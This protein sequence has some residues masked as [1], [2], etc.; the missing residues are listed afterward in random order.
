MRNTCRNLGIALI[1][2]LL[3]GAP[4]TGHAVDDPPTDAA[5]PFAGYVG[6]PGATI[7]SLVPVDIAA[8]GQGHV[9]LLD[10]LRKV[11]EKRDLDGRLVLSWPVGFAE[12]FRSARSLT[13]DLDGNVYVGDSAASNTTVNDEHAK[14]VKYSPMGQRLGSWAFPVKGMGNNGRTLVAASK[15][16]NA[17][18]L[19]D[20]QGLPVAPYHIGGAGLT[21]R[22][23]DAAIGADGTVYV[24]D[25]YHRIRKFDAAGA[26]LATYDKASGHDL[27]QPASM[28]VD[29]T[30]NLYVTDRRHHRV[31]KISPDGVLLAQVGSEGHG[32][33]RFL[34]PHGLTIDARGHLWVANY[35]G[36]NL[37]KFDADLQHLLTV[38]GDNTAPG[39]FAGPRGVAIDRDGHVYVGDM[40]TNSV[41]V[42][43]P[44]GNFVT[45]WGRRG[46]GPGQVFNFPRI[47]AVDDQDHVYVASDENVRKFDR[48]G[49]YLAMWEET[50]VRGDTKC[51]YA[52][53][54]R[55]MAVDRL[56]RIWMAMHDD[57]RLVR[58]DPATGDRT[59]F[60]GPGT[61]PGQFA[62][63]WGLAIRG[64]E[65][66]VADSGNARIQ[67]L[68]LDGQVL[69]TFGRR[70]AAPGRLL[71]PTGLAVDAAGRVFVA[72]AGNARI[73]VLAPDGT[74]LGQWGTRGAG[75]NQFAEV[76]ALAVDR[77]GRVYA[78]DWVNATVQRFGDARPEPP[79]IGV[80]GRPAYVPGVD[81]AAYLWREGGA[82][83]LWKLRVSGL[84]GQSFRVVVL[85][86]RGFLRADPLGL[87]SCSDGYTHH[88]YGL[89]LECTLSAA[90][91]TAGVDLGID[92]QPQAGSELIVS[93]HRDQRSNPG[94]LRVGRAA[95]T[96]GV[97]GWM[98]RMGN[99]PPMAPFAPGLDRGVFA[100]A[101]VPRHFD[102][103]ASGN[104]T[105]MR[106]DLHVASSQP[107]GSVELHDLNPSDGVE[108]TA[109]TLHYRGTVS[110]RADR[111][112][113]QAPFHALLFFGLRADG[114]FSPYLLN[115]SRDPFAFGL[116]PPDA[117]V[118]PVARP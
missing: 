17:A 19:F 80:D 90:H 70:G 35:H 54:A 46:Q 85:S 83:G 76:H 37:Q 56:G 94:L 82:A 1:A 111:M 108:H 30:G 4:S 86:T 16:L 55:G 6:R 31:L 91:A 65:L 72:D 44:S 71:R 105:P 74:P 84:Q 62:R 78:T 98:I 7:P 64:D 32:P 28:V 10:F 58:L 66:Y 93:V 73:Q 102:L 59:R 107:F 15:F 50:G 2:A 67:V 52:R 57:D 113:A 11:V 112:R 87:E 20:L 47:V 63:P 69:R 53:C 39:E 79:R 118:V 60:G 77:W 88:P 5:L 48:H 43:D 9:Y 33:G 29:A 96:L 12:G 42:F 14:V 103:A 41:T 116:G 114:L 51:A 75:P 3:V 89:L 25:G 101:S 115:E 8:D 100:G 45:Q 22:P 24:T 21:F 13:A 27:D 106:L 36:K 97:S 26:L 18:G 61:A 38:G 40:W 34:Q 95:R 109:N 104:G 68:D 117:Y 81:S 92:L 110:T 99:L 49:N 23:E